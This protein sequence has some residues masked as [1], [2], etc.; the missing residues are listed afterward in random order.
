MQQEL[1]GGILFYNAGDK[2]HEVLTYSTAAADKDANFLA[3]WQMIAPAQDFFEVPTQLEIRQTGEIIGVQFARDIEQKFGARGVIRIDA[4]HDPEQE[5]D[6]PEKP[7]PARAPTQALAKVR[8]EELWRN[9]LRSVIQSHLDDCEAARAAGGAPKSARGFT[10]RAL[11]LLGVKDP[12][13]EYF[14]SLMNGQQPGAPGNSDV[15]ML[16]ARIDMLMGLLI[17]QASGEKLTPEKLQELMKTPNAVGVAPTG[18]VITS[19]VAT[20]KI[21]KPLGNEGGVDHELPAARGKQSRAQEAEKHL[22]TD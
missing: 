8:G 15:A 2:I 21:T 14:H 12:G 11:K 5:S 13:E 22:G 17:A 20:G 19:G 18:K 9:Y 16:N 4:R 3:R 1:A 7:L 6:D 10:K